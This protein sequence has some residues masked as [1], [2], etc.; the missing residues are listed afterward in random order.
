[1]FNVISLAGTISWQRNLK[2][3]K[4]LPRPCEAHWLE[5]SS[6]M[7][8]YG[9]VCV[10]FCMPEQG[11][12]KNECPVSWWDVWSGPGHSDNNG[13]KCSYCLKF[14]GRYTRCVQW[15][16]I[17]TEGCKEVRQEN[18]EMWGGWRLGETE[19]KRS[20]YCKQKDVR[21]DLHQQTDTALTELI[22]RFLSDCLRSQT[23]AFMQSDS[24]VM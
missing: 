2:F 4:G 5:S 1:M 6:C 15:R 18:D 20:A 22:L 19:R 14:T 23:K 9:C 24:R 17:Q 7:I 13:M 16:G 3:R 11:A 8:A 12:G 21:A 10:C